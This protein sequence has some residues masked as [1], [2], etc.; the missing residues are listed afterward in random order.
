MADRKMKHI[1]MVED[2]AASG[3]KEARSYWT[4]I[5]V[6]FENA[7]GSWS[8]QLSAIPVTGKMQLRDPAP[9][10]NSD[11]AVAARAR[12]GR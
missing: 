11:N 3:A 4:K 12:G 1:W 9:P 2:V 8:L 10:R 5:G 6:A 7:D